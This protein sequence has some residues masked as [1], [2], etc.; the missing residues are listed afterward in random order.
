MAGCTPK[1]FEGSQAGKERDTNGGPWETRE[2]QG[3]KLKHDFTLT[4]KK[5][6][7]P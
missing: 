3:E 5:C 2:A 6:W 7:G 4:E 1:G